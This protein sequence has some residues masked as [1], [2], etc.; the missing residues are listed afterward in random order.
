MIG[1][2]KKLSLINLLQNGRSIPV[3]PAI[4]F[5]SQRTRW[6][7]SFQ[8]PFATNCDQLGF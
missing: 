1:T 2:P 7:F 5:V 8:N 4:T 6:L 3:H